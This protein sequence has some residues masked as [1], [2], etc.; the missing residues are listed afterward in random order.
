M[1]KKAVPVLDYTAFQIDEISSEVK[2]LCASINYTIVATLLEKTG[3]ALGSFTPRREDC[4]VAGGVAANSLI[5]SEFATYA[6]RRGL[7]FWFRIKSIVEIMYAMIAL[8]G[9]KLAARGYSNSMDF[10]AIPRG[11]HVLA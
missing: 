6:Q 4:I 11:K 9:V 8:A 1:Y 10:E 2:D 5:R 7:K 3:R